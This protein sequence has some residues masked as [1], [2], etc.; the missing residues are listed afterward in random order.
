M[1]LLNIRFSFFCRSTH[2]NEQGKN[3]IVLRI[4][5]R[6]ERREIL[7]GLYCHKLHWDSS[8]HLVRKSDKTAKTIT[9]VYV[10]AIN[11]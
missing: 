1:E 10:E 5:F 7:T 4:T 3:P 2:V 11:Y 8:A 9:H 6:G